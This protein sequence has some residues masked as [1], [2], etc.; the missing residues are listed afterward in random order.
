MKKG[1]KLIAQHHV[2]RFNRQEG[3]KRIASKQICFRFYEVGEGG[4]GDK[5]HFQNKSVERK[6]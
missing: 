1:A 6:K 3:S 5:N 2:E 4:S